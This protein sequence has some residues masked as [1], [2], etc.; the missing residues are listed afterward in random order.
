MELQT[1]QSKNCSLTFFYP[2]RLSTQVSKVN[3]PK[4]ASICLYTNVD[5]YTCT[6]DRVLKFNSDR[7]VQSLN[8]TTL[9]TGLVWVHSH[10]S[11]LPIT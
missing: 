9:V 2:Y 5:C 8:V 3:V 1:K 11:S 7:K 4:V 10:P 6:V